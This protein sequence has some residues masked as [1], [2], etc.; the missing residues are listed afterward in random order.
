MNKVQFLANIN[1]N[2]P[3]NYK[4]LP[5]FFRICCTNVIFNDLFNQIKTKGL[6]GRNCLFL[7]PESLLTVSE[8]LEILDKKIDGES[9]YLNA[10][11]INNRMINIYN[12]LFIN[13]FKEQ[14]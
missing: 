12:Q 5:K 8:Y 9:M 3:N 14:R 7:F 2:Y 4:K 11:V 10:I 13:I 6:N 1:V